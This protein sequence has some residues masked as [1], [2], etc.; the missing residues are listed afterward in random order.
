MNVAIIIPA[1]NPDERLIAYVSELQNAGQNH[2][3][4]VDDGSSSGKRPVFF[5][6]HEMGCTVLRNAVNLGKGRTL[7]NTFNYCLTCSDFQTE[8][9]PEKRIGGVITVDSDGQHTVA[10]VLEIQKALSEN[11]DSLVLGVRDFGKDNVPA[12]SA[13]GNKMTREAIR[14]LYGGN[15]TDTQTGLRGI[16]FQLLP[17]YL[18]LYGERFEYETNMLI[19]SLRKKVPVKQIEIQTVY[20][21]ENKGTHFRPVVDSWKIYRLIFGTFFKYTFSSLSS[22][23]IDLGLFQLLTML[24]GGEG[25]GIRVW[26]ATIGARI[27]SSLYNYSVNRNIVFKG[28]QKTGT[29][30]LKYY[31]LCA[32]QMCASAALVYFFCTI[33]GLPE[34]VIKIFVDTFLF[35]LSFQIQ[36]RWIFETA[37]DNSTS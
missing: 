23:L 5:R 16:S 20:E 13:F 14:L 27:I 37:A 8:N 4:V 2:I 10:D 11:A 30:L 29:T 33:A 36:R 7:K 9:D 35:L 25:I 19:E 21:N 22:A 3:I 31:I 18:D 17:L 12:K 26:M 34:I 15:I 28:K 24:L 1:L 32:C 6:L